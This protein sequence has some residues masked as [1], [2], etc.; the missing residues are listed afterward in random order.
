[1]VSSFALR[2]KHQS[3]TTGRKMQNHFVIEAT[4]AR[5]DDDLSKPT[6]TEIEG[7]PGY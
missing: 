3:K 4:I 2:V 5:K 1:M 6:I 7:V